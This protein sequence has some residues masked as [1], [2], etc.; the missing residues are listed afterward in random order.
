MK[1]SSGESGVK[2]NNTDVVKRSDT[3]G[4][5]KRSD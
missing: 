1:R 5:M 3:E 4:V 2:K